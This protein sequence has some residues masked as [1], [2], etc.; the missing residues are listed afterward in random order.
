MGFIHFP[1][2]T[3]VIQGKCEAN[4]VMNYFAQALFNTSYKEKRH[5][6]HIDFSHSHPSLPIS[7]LSFHF[8]Q[9]A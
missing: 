5:Q 8:Q 9:K 4:P 1:M 6:F 2:H 7:F 3:T